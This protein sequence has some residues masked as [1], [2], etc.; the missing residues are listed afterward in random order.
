MQKQ[1]EI[2]HKLN[3]SIPLIQWSYL[4]LDFSDWDF[5]RYHFRHINLMT[6]WIFYERLKFL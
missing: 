2:Q 6:M 1:A 4:F 3:S 5:S